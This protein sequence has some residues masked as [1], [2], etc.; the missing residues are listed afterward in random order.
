MES[1]ETINSQSHTENKI[2]GSISLPNLKFHNKAIMIVTVWHWN[3]DRL[4]DQ[5]VRIE[6]PT[7]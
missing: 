2:C 1:G 6:Y 7:T 3:T 5:W 4:S